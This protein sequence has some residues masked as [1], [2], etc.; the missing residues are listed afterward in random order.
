M[1]RQQAI[2]SKQFTNQARLFKSSSSNVSQCD[3]IAL[4]RWHGV[5]M[6]ITEQTETKAT[7]IVHTLTTRTHARTHRYA[8]VLAC[9]CVRT[10]MKIAHCPVAI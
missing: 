4:R 10:V 8:Y 2:I 7:T 6:Q 1:L 5:F 9:V 3:L